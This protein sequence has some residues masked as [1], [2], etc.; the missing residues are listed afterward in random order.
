MQSQIKETKNKGDDPPLF[1]LSLVAMFLLWGGLFF[2]IPVYLGINNQIIFNIIGFVFLIISLIGSLI[3][4]SN[5]WR[6]EA[7]SYWG[8]ASVFILPAILLHLLVYHYEI[9]GFWRAV[10]KVIVIVLLFIGIPFITIGFSYLTWKHNGENVEDIKATSEEER[11]KTPTNNIQ[12]VTSLII[13]I[14]ALATAIVQL[15]SQINN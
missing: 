12:L 6:N 14:L 9:Y 1:G 10:I 4:I 5:L 15:V 13:A 3:E 11:A 8:V 2:Y 7:F